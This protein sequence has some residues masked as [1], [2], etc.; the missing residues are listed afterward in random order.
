YFQ[1]LGQRII[2][3]LDEMTEQGRVYRVDM[4]L[5]PFGDAGPLV[6][7]FNALELY[8]QESGRDWERYAYVKARAVTAAALS[9]DLFRNVLR[10]FVY[11]RYLDYGVFAALRDMREMIAR[12]VKRRDLRENIKLGPGGIREI[13]FIAQCLQLI[14]GGSQPALRR[15]S[16]IDVLLVLEEH[17]F[18]PAEAAAD[19][20][21]A[22]E[23]LRNLENRMQAAEDRQTHDLPSGSQARAMLVSAM[24]LSGWEQLVE[25][26]RRH[27]HKVS[28]WFDKLIPQPATDDDQEA[29]QA[30]DGIWDGSG[31]EVDAKKLLQRMQCVESAKVL[32]ELRTFADGSLFRRLDQPGGDRLRQLL[33][34][35]VR[36]AAPRLD[37]PL[38]LQRLF[39]VLEAVGRRSAYFSMLSEN[40]AALER[41]VELCGASGFLTRQ[42][43]GSPLL[44]DELLDPN[45]LNIVPDRQQFVA[46]L[47]NRI[48]AAAADDPE[49]QHDALRR[50]QN[51]AVFRV[52][53]ADLDQRLPLMKVSDRLTDI[54]ELVLQRALHLVWDELLE[55]QPGPMATMDVVAPGFLVL[56]YG[57]L[58]GLELA[59]G[60]DLDLVFLYDADLA[61]PQDK[62][63]DGVVFYSRL[64]RRLANYLSMQTPAGR[65]YEVDMRLRPS[66]QA[67]LLVSSFQAFSQ[68]QQQ[69]AWT[70]EHQALLRARPVAGDQRLARRFDEL[71]GEVLTRHVAEDGL[72]E[73]VARMRS[74]MRRELSR[75][76]SGQFDIKQDAGGIADIEFLVQYLVLREARRNERLI[77]WPDNMRQLE[78][79][80]AGGVLEAGQARLLMATYLAYRR[81]L[82]H[83]S[84]EGSGGV[85]DGKEFL[86]QASAVSVLWQELIGE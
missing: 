59:Y 41:L 69:K 11:R 22:Y 62:L 50:F 5:R 55:R 47:D 6:L 35:I 61:W 66:G 34:A 57:K 31:S 24:N 42:V 1:R 38:V 20:A 25:T 44:L 83:L 81:R 54:A 33:P 78:A 53:L 75:S 14:R 7:S 40:P 84:L 43:A 9:A 80:S 85:V 4:R 26:L 10:P 16:L 72:A 27:T 45:L 49:Q 21:E 18:L 63:E 12:D 2:Y 13:E 19:L 28:H 71:R 76:A 32:R 67:G 52:A 39:T 68:Y 17:R 82:H 15:R 36:L 73:Q 64:G 8:L 70:W 74:K 65:L 30:F 79:L 48:Q 60:S 77:A 37:A 29:R 23:F 46:E 3:L 56:G 86:A 51:A 58:G